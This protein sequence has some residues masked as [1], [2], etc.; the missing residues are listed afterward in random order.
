MGFPD[1]A[2]IFMQDLL[3]RLGVE[4]AGSKQE[5]AQ[6]TLDDLLEAALQLVETGD[7]ESF[8]AR[9]VAKIS[10]YALG[11]VSRQLVHIE[12]VFLWAIEE[13][14]RQN[15]EDLIEFI[16]NADP[17][18]KSQYFSY[19]VADFC[20]ERISLVKPKV[21]IFFEARI[22]KRAEYVS[23]LISYPD[24][25]IPHIIGLTEKNQSGTFRNIN[26]DNAK[27]IVRSLA[28]AVERPFLE[29]DPIAGTKDH[30][31]QLAD[32][33]YRLLQA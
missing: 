7:P 10:G 26:Q 27:L 1:H 21:M 14:R 28:V 31:E 3:K 16:D 8:T 25:V 24:M 23:D 5:R 6:K 15:F 33:I 18:Y 19:D 11:T 17:N 2:F 32:L 20:I 12:N 9:N 30:R 13:R 29:S 22:L 4:F